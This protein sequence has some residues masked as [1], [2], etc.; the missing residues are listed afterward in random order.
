MFDE[1]SG[2]FRERY[3]WFEQIEFMFSKKKSP[4]AGKRI[5]YFFGSLHFSLVSVSHCHNWH[6]LRDA[7]LAHV[8]VLLSLLWQLKI[9]LQSDGNGTCL[10][11]MI[12]YQKGEKNFPT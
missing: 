1:H 11:S 4:Y 6:W 7:R 8:A 12:C 9:V 3:K 10:C 2:A 5:G